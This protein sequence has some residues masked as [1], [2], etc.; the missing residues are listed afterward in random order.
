M[1]IDKHKKISD[2]LRN[3]ENSIINEINLSFILTKLSI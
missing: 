2:F 1:H 3:E